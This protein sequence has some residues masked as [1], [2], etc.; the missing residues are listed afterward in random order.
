MHRWIALLFLLPTALVHAA[1]Y[2]VGPSRPYP[3]L[4]AL[5]NA[6]DLTGGDL[7]EVDGGTTYPGGVVIGEDDGGSA[8]NPV[9][10]RGI[11][12]AG[13]R[14]HIA[15]G[16]NTVEFRQSDHVVFEGFEVSGGSARCILQG[17]HD[18][19]V[20]DSEIHACPAHGILGTDQLSGSFTLEYSE[21]HDA[22][23]G[24][25]QHAL[26]IQSDE[27]AHPGSVFRMRHCYVHDGN[28]GN[29]LKSRHERSEIH[30]NWFEGAAY[31]ELE[32]I[33]PDEETQQPGWSIDLVREDQDVVGNVI[34]H[35]NP[36]FGA[37]IRV[38][39][40][41]S[42]QSR[43]R[44]RF[45]NNTILVTSGEDATVFRVFDGIQAV[46]AH[47][48]VIFA[49]AGGTIR[50]ERTVEAVWANGR[51]V[52][53]SNNWVP[54]DATFVPPE[55]SGTLQGT[56]PGFANVAL[57]DFAPGPASQLRDAA[58][59]SPQPVP[60]YAVPGTLFPPLYQPRGVHVAPGSA[61][62]RPADGAL[63]I[64]AIERAGNLIFADGFDA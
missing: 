1:T 31:H 44:V 28:G 3:T 15:G 42:G 48:N 18:V 54:D 22:G 13:Q 17:A 8:G 61:T 16:T 43:G 47:N 63:D 33:G 41:G 4:N 7:V 56:D 25:Q 34:V 38:G 12:G 35:T 53:G 52:G 51:Q 49:S 39:G 30:Y 32:L 11:R 29:L 27:I 36:D 59:P 58:N 50:V 6:V 21:I 23:N 24:T 10:I 57:R 64:G 26:Y 62:P 40:D 19:T 46:E 20:R 2:R 14:P 37:V 45:A 55:W 60:G 5:V 9:V